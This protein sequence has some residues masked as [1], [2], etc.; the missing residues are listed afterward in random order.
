[1]FCRQYSYLFN[2]NFLQEFLSANLPVGFFIRFIRSKGFEWQEDISLENWHTNEK[3]TIKKVDKYT[4]L[5]SR[6]PVGTTK[7]WP[8]TKE[9]E[10]LQWEFDEQN[11]QIRLCR[12]FRPSRRYRY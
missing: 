10:F 7:E 5:F 3:L 11:R 6:Y 2:Q 8:Q 12:S 9:K 1:M 4:L